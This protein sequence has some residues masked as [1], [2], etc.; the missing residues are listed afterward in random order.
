MDDAA[1][2]Q[3]IMAVV[4][5][6]LAGKLATPAFVERY[7]RTRNGLLDS[8]WRAF[9][10]KFGTMMGVMDSAAHVYSA[11]ADRSEWEIDEQQLRVEASAVM[12]N[13]RRA[14]FLD[15]SS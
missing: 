8:N 5:D 6:W 4:Q 3:T 13:L 7:W 9:E 2:R 12:E 10:G 15:R 14:G 1:A 11:D